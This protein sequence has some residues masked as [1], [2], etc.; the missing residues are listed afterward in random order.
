MPS[1]SDESSASR[2]PQ[3]IP[4]GLNAGESSAS[5]RRAVTLIGS[6]HDCH[7]QLQSSTVSS[8]HAM[9]VRTRDA[10]HIRDLA[11][12]TGI[13]VNGRPLREGRLV[14][15]DELCI[16]KFIFRFSAAPKP[17]PSRDAATPRPDTHGEQPPLPV[18]VRILLIGRDAGCDVQIVGETVSGRHAVVLVANHEGYIRDLNSRTGTF[19]NGQK[20][21]QQKLH[22]GDKIR[23]GPATLKVR[24]DDWAVF[25]EAEKPS[26]TLLDQ[27]RESPAA[28]AALGTQTLVDE[29]PQ[30]ATPPPARIRP[31]PPPIAA[32][33]MVPVAPPLP[34]VHA[35]P[36]AA[37]ASEAST[38]VGAD[39][40][41]KLN[42]SLPAPD[43]DRPP[44]RQRVRRRN[45]R[46]AQWTQ[47]P[48]YFTWYALGCQVALLFLGDTPLRLPLRIATYGGSLLLLM[49]LPPKYQTHPSL[50][51]LKWMPAILAIG[52]LH[53]EHNTMMA[54][55]AQIL[56][57][58]SIY[59]PL[60]WVAG[61]KPDF[62]VFRRILLVLWMFN[63]A[64]AATGVLQ[65]YFPGQFQGA[66]S[67]LVSSRATFQQ[68]A[69]DVV[70]ADGTR[71]LRPFGLTD[72][73][74]GAAEGALNAIILGAGIL[75]AERH[76]LLRSCAAAGM[77]VSLFAI[78]LSQV[79]VELVM[80]VVCVIV[81]L[82]M[83]MRRGEWNKVIATATVIGAVAIFGAAWAFAIGGKQTIERFATLTAENPADVYSANRGF[84]LNELI[85]YDL[86]KYPFGAG[87]GRW[88]MMN[89][90]FGN[91]ND[92]LY[93]EIMW[94]SWLFDGGIAL[95]LVY[96]SAFGIAMWLSWK[97]AVRRADQ[98]GLWSGVV[99]ALN[100]AALAG[101]FVFP[102]FTIQA[103]M[104]IWMI[105]ACLFSASLAA[106]DTTQRES[107][108]DPAAV[109]VAPSGADDA[110]PSRRRRRATAERRGRRR[111]ELQGA[112]VPDAR[113]M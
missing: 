63:L 29:A 107:S 85:T 65:V 91:Q 10:I 54:G 47:W 50:R 8:H 48:L 43:A 16:G 18:S 51:L 72:T 22:K 17:N 105:N 1:K 53:P 12:R 74:G 96:V 71:I 3:L 38:D 98:L 13:V 88:G 32:R 94:T 49:L 57:Y 93:S 110:R 113:G 19:V 7:I 97:L 64:S 35:H 99:F 104:E 92:P 112:A 44:F 9:I 25:A 61:S 62:A 95:V 90:Y 111:F 41:A 102:L 86:P 69:A 84:F 52:L 101:T 31:Q 45:Q 21:H 70:L 78:F 56:L 106:V 5:L 73:P 20:I 83:L 82:G 40:G 79:R 33:T 39:S 11:S 59:A 108:R 28:S 100:I 81:L 37:A 55:L 26:H 23:I 46:P 89:Y 14:E 6:E 2:A 87:L 77:L 80:A 109:E 27:S 36:P 68:G 58:V 66:T 30:T 67:S 76:P 75:L 42:A 24:H 4:L 103:G 60:A 15:G 34:P